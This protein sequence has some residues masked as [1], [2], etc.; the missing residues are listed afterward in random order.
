MAEMINLLA[1]TTM[2]NTRI[3]VDVQK[4]VSVFVERADLKLAL[5]IIEFINLLLHNNPFWRLWNIM[6]LKILWKMEHLLF[7]SKCS[8]FHNIF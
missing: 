5:N 6:N 8:I 4:D 2:A 7:F 3:A 1:V